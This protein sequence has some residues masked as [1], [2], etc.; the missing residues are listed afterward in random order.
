M[1][2]PADVVH[3]VPFLNV[4]P[5]AANAPKSESDLAFNTTMTWPVCKGTK[6]EFLHCADDTIPSPQPVDPPAADPDCEVRYI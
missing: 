5:L 3:I 6:L 2:N 4:P 1:S